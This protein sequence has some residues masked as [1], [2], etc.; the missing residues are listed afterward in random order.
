M[1]DFRYCLNAST[2]RAT[3]ILEKIRIAGEVGYAGIELWHDEMDA[4]VQAGGTL[5]EIRT[6][7]SDA[8]LAV[9][10]T[11]F[12]KGW[13]DTL[14]D[15]HTRAMD[16]I[17]RRLE[18]ARE[19]GAAHAIAGPPLGPVDLAVGARRYAE[20]LQIGREFGVRPVIE[21]LGFS[22][23]MNRLEDALQI[24]KD[25]GDEDGTVVLDP[26]HCFRGD[27]PMET[28][29]QLRPEQ[30][31]IS[32][33]ND[34]PAFPPREL[35]QDPDRVLPGEGVV[36]LQ[37]WCKLLKQIGYDGWL[38]LELFNRQLWAADPR[39]VARD[40]LERMRRFAES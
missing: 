22:Q 13:W 25:C 8:G 38:S 16:E 19:V 27:G 36:D 18:Q 35:Q 29:Q 11:I 23:H 24:L 10:T 1:S 9:P 37:N 5:A 12:L 21:Y 15:V 32:H 31:A 30:I 39:Q 28:I 14:D 26:F 40:G 2:I 3:P 4:H 34:A 7:L 20:L 6:A 33:F 17:R